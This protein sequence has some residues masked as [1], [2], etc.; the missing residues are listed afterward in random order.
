[1]LKSG[2]HATIA[3]VLLALTIPLRLSVGKP[4]D[5]TSPLHI[6]EHAI[7][8]WSAFLILPVFGF[9]NAGVSLAG[10]KPGMLLDP[11]TLG[12]ALG[13]FVGKQLG[14]FGF[15]LALVRLGWAQRPARATW[16]QVY[17]VALLCGVG[18]TM[19]L[20]IGL[21]AFASSPELEAETKIGV[22]VGS[23]L[24]MAAGAL[25]LRLA[26][27]APAPATSRRS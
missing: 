13:L 11:V 19:S 5:P 12:V 23:L 4:D 15:V 27:R 10:F 3:G 17:G 26:P 18:F 8:P 24:C 25:V 16:L 14:V 20:F 22:L 21:L 9:A 1:V 6:L 2:V 7:H